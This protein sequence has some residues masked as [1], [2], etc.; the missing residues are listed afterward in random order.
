[1]DNSLSLINVFHG[2]KV[3]VQEKPV[4]S[5]VAIQFRWA[6][7]TLWYRLPHDEGL[8]YQQRVI[9][10]SSTGQS[11]LEAITP[12]KMNK[13]GH[14]IAAQFEGFPLAPDAGTDYQIELSLKDNIHPEW[15]TISDFPLSIKYSVLPEGVPQER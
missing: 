11:L 9:V 2:M 1:M 6:V 15:T 10:K 8:D 3:T 12:F 13:P 7:F 4:T 5:G 14:R